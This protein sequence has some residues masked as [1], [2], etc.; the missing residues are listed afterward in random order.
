[1]RKL[2]ILN[3]DS[4]SDLHRQMAET[5]A[6]DCTVTVTTL[7][8]PLFVRDMAVIALLDC[9]FKSTIPSEPSVPGVANAQL[10]CGSTATRVFDP[11]LID[12]M[13]A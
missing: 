4:I 9:W 8:V 6:V 5:T 13:P 2:N 11:V 3:L 7:V 10:R 12:T 1:M